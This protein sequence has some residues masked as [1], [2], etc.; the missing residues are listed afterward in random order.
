VKSKD[1]AILELCRNCPHRPKLL[2]FS[3]LM[4]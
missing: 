4:F 2:G 3:T 1:P